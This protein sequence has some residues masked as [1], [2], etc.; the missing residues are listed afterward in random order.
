MELEKWI[1][2]GMDVVIYYGPKI[3]GAILIWLIGS[4][5]I[6]R[7]VKL[8]RRI[9]EKQQY[10]VSLTKFLLN[11]LR[12]GLKILLVIIILGTL[13][14]STASF[15]AVIA[16]AGLAIG[17]ALQGSLGNFAGG[18]LLMIFKPIRVGDLIEAQGELGVVEEIQIF[19]TVIITPENKTVVI[20]NGALSNGNIVNYS[21]KGS[22]RVDLVVGVDYGSDLQKAQDVLMEAITAHPKTLKNPAPT[23][24]VSE[25]A[26]S[27]VNFVVRPWAKTEDYWAVRFD[28]LKACKEALDKAGVEIPFPHMVQIRK[29]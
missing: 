18:I 24:A 5:L 7:L 6:R 27:S 20:P 11:F 4:W 14:V 2:K 15:A 17:L 21:K 12:Y 10:D 28:C 23:V 16:A 29:Q 8:S 26:D 19:N 25:L 1:D 13:G 9:M 3:I 22:L